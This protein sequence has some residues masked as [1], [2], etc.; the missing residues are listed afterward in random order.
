MTRHASAETLARFRGGGLRRAATR[1]VRAHLDSCA[2]CTATYEALGEIPGLLAATEV[3]PMPAHL[4]AR[5]ETALAT[6]SAHRAA[7]SPS[8]RQARP[9]HGGR[10]QPGHA[11]RTARG[12]NW[13]RL[14]APALRVA[15]AAAA[16]VVVGGGAVA[17]AQLGGSSGPAESSSASS[18]SGAGSSSAGGSARAAAPNGLVRPGTKTPVQFGPLVRYQAGGQT[19]AVRPVQTSTNY[20]PA[21][22]TQQVT[23]A[24]A[25]ARSKPTAN[26]EHGA[27]AER[28][29]AVA[30]SRG[31][32][33]AS[34][35]LRAA[36]RSAWWIS[37]SSA[38]RQRPSSSPRPPV[39]RPRR[40]GWWAR[41]AHAQRATY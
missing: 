23:A 39:L 15:A 19:A 35:G 5:I 13:P 11:L 21:H 38:G 37:P 29:D 10:P 34:A 17:V 9:A 41:D 18:G 12:R 32:L 31:Y 28:A 22:L 40:S 36:S 26:P 20:Q 1:R 30:S 4:A 14:P 16:V 3:P 7:G 33:P 27:A 25:Q 8:V 24:L 6:E 2:R